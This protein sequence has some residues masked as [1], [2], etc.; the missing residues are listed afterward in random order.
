MIMS[1][2][3]QLGHLGATNCAP[4]PITP[5]TRPKAVKASFF[6]IISSPCESC[7]QTWRR[8]IL[9]V[10]KIIGLLVIS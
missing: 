7:F 1:F 3:P 4:N 10:Y 8:A 2:V 9:L 6:P 5:I